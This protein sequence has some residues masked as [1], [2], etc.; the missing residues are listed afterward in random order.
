[1]PSYRAPLNDLKFVL[2][3]F[4]AL[5]RYSN[6]AGFSEASPDLINAVLEEGAKFCENE[7]APLNRAGDEEGCARQPDGTVATPTGFKEAYAK[8]VAGGWQ[9][10]SLPADYGGQG[11]PLAVGFAFDEMM[12]AANLS[13]AMYPGLTSGAVA[14]LNATASEDIKQRFLPPM[15][16]GRWTGTMNLTEPQC[17]TDLGL[18]RSKA[19]AND[20]GSYAVS[21]TKI[22]IS[23]GEHDLAE[24]IVHLVLARLP[25]AP[26]GTKGISLFVVPKYLPGADGA[27]GALNN[28]FC[29]RLEDKM[30][31]HGNATAEINYDGATGWLVG[32]ENEGLKNMFVM[33][34]AARLGVGQ[35]GLAISEAAYQNAA[36]YARE[37]LQG[38]ALTGAKNPEGQA[39][40]IIVHPDVRRM[41]MNARAFNEGAR[42]L[43]LWAA[44]QA[45][46]AA[47]AE[48]AEERERAEDRLSVLTPVIKGVFTDRGYANATE[49]QQVFGGHGYIREWGMEQFVRDARI[50]MLYE[51]T[52]GIQAL[53]LVGRKLGRNN[54]R[55]VRGMLQEMAAYGK[56]NDGGDLAAFTRPLSAA[57]DDLQ[58]ATM[59]LLQHSPESPDNAGAAATNYMHLMGLTA[60][61]YIWAQMAERAQAKLSQGTDETVFLENKLATGRYFM[62]HIL[63][64]TASLR[65]K[66]EAGAEAVMALPEEAF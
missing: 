66:V 60:L 61:G 27:P 18:L 36:G 30:G 49:A 16:A 22:F 45:D 20:D 35:Q 34:N 40:P 56:E 38:R 10:L 47:K 3:D 58:A 13:F 64:E 25:D 15:I 28:V 50:A 39:D 5:E 43:G 23:S 8:F 57:V 7:L 63:P 21:G 17:G 51:G 32:A 6:L 59:W 1:M 26:E 33:M 48:T 31:I 65:A 29:P 44:L 19:A 55:A 46:L 52:N 41:L 2:N 53:D 11:L 4:L 42:A 14:C 24:N 62:R 9:G 12:M 37:R 54:G